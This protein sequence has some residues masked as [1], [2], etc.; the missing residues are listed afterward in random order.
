[1]SVSNGLHGLQIVFARLFVRS[2]LLFEVTKENSKK[3]K[4]SPVQRMGTE[5]NV[6]CSAHAILEFCSFM[7]A[8]WATLMR[9]FAFKSPFQ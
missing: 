9:H 4:F 2:A 7:R 3:N 1:M 8:R 6:F 5:T